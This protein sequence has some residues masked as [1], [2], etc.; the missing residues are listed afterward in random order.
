MTLAEHESR[1]D[2]FERLML[3]ADNRDDRV[4]FGTAFLLAI[5]ERN[6]ARSVAELVRIERARGLRA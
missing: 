3:E 4:A 6:A 5:A 1:I 2:K